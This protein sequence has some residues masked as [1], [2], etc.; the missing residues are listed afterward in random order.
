MS[1]PKYEAY[2]DS[3]VE[4]LGEVPEHWT[5]LRLK[6]I[7]DSS[8]PIT[9]GIVQAGENIPAGIPY[10]RPM[11]MSD[12]QGVKDEDTLLKTSIEIA[13]SYR[14]SSLKPGDIVC[15][16]G[17][18]FGKVM[19][20]PASLNGANLT[21]GTARIS[22]SENNIKGYIFWALRSSVVFQQWESCVGGATFR[23]L[24]LGPLS[25]TYIPGPS[26]QEQTQIARFLDNET[27]RIDALIAEQERLIELLKEKRQAVISHAVT[28]GLD[29]T[30]P[31]KDSGVDWLGEVPEHWELLPL[32]YLCNFYGGGTPSKENLEYWNGD[33]PWVS[34][35]DMKSFLI[36][37][38][39]DKITREAITESSTTMIPTGSLLI[40]V[41]SGILQRTVPVAINKIPVTLNQDMKAL[42]F[43]EF[44][45]SEFI[46]YFIKGLEDSVLLA[47]KKQGATVE[48]IEFEYLA[49]TLIPVPQACEVD[50]ILSQLRKIDAQYEALQNEASLSINL[51]QERRSALISAA[52]TGKIDVRG[53]QAP[54]SAPPAPNLDPAHG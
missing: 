29:P 24:N 47:W 20:V 34:P 44:R 12:E 52:V 21:Q 9:Y 11:D 1:F 4:W 49:N 31:M 15:S 39:I 43:R 13:F 16:I 54:A 26:L 37:D 10:I 33:I 23:A 38:T 22:V 50:A 18:S 51:L 3:G 25:E 8:R 46:A 32:K 42:C 17:P 30:V 19:I 6:Q 2:K 7:V 36:S 41:R 40:V 5:T 14:R 35:K 48:S 53:W 28:K 27:A 45:L